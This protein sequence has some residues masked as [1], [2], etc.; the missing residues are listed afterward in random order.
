MD[1]EDPEIT[2]NSLGDC[3][4]CLKARK[5]L[6]MVTYPNSFEQWAT[7]VILKRKS[8]QSYD[9]ILGLSGGLDSS[10]LLV[11]LVEFGVKPLV[12]HVDA[13]WNSSE[14]VKNIY[15]L[16]TKLKV[17]LQVE[18][19]DWDFVRNL[20]IAFLKSG[21]R[22]QDIPQDYLFLTHL[23]KSAKDNKI[24]NIFTGSNYATEN[25]LPTNWG[26]SAL[27]YKR[28]KGIMTEFGLRP[29]PQLLP[30]NNLHFYLKKNIFRS[31]SVHEPLNLMTYSKELARIYLQENYAWQNY[32]GKHTESQF[33]KYFQEVY[34]VNRFGINKKKAHLSSLIV[35]NEIDRA[36]ALNELNRDLNNSDK[37]YFI[38]K[39]IAN[40]LGIHIDTLRQFEA[41]VQNYT[42]I[43]FKGSKIQYHLLRVLEKITMLIKAKFI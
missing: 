6:Y 22:N 9:G 32:E 10:Y 12:F 27:D 33:T 8:N 16:V 15:N 18:V 23:F 38:Q 31:I 20:Q 42:N 36:T 41:P 25:I 26:E 24:K 39:Y 19:V 30:F 40:K 21:L 5:N 1:Q 34:L 28:V 29:H 37:S 7:K 35:N 43:K 4:H 17:D 3:N 2:F 14:S 13:G 11:K